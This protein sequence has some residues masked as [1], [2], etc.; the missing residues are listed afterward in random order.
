MLREKAVHDFRERVGSGINVVTVKLDRIESTAG[1]VNGCVPTA[2]DSKVHVFRDYMN[3]ARVIRGELLQK[4][5]CAV[6]GVI[7]NDNDIEIEVTPLRQGTPDSIPDSLDPIEHWD[8]YRGSN[9]KSGLFRSVANSLRI[10]GCTH[11]TCRGVWFRGI[12]ERS[13]KPC[14]DTFKMGCA[15]LFHLFLHLTV[16]RGYIVKLLLAASTQVILDIFI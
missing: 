5:G 16:G 9:R 12:R 6:G 7:V 10:A 8:Y 1:T 14:P 15:G 4:A 2:T 3:E 13:V 11:K